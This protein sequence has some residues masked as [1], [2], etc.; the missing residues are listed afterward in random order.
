MT[1]GRINNEHSTNVF[2]VKT[3]LQIVSSCNLRDFQRML[4]KV[5]SKHTYT[6]FDL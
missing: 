1:V 4:L 6:H 2:V 5:I 3:G